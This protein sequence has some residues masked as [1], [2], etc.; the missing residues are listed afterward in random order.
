MG[1]FSVLESSAARRT[2]E[3][4]R[5]SEN[6]RTWKRISNGMLMELS[7]KALSSRRSQN[8][9]TVPAQDALNG[10]TVPLARISHCANFHQSF[11]SGNAAHLHETSCERQVFLPLFY[12]SWPE[13]PPKINRRS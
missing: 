6:N 9:P 1:Y 2:M 12:E 13:K 8:G 3:R 7:I 5:L 4:R 11:R 10:W